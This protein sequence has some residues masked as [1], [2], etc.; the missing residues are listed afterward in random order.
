MDPKIGTL[1]TTS[2]TSSSISPPKTII[3]LLST[4]TVVSIS[5]LFVIISKPLWATP[6][7]PETPCLIVKITEAPSLIWGVISNSI[8]TSCLDVV[9]K[10]FEL[11]VPRLSPVVIGISWPINNLAGSLSIARIEGVDKIFESVSSA[12][13]FKIPTKLSSP[14]VRSPKPATRPWVFRRD[15]IAV[16]VKVTSCS[17]SAAPAIASKSAPEPENLVIPTGIL[18]SSLPE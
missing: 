12:I 3:W 2:W 14:F 15:E 13:A 6:A 5:L 4:K 16:V 7:I 18:S 17:S 8:P 1:E 11:F 9:L 10:G